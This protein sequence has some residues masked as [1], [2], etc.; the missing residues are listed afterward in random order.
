MFDDDGLGEAPP[1]TPPPPTAS[2][3]PDPRPS[4][5]EPTEPEAPRPSQ[6]SPSLREPFQESDEPQPGP[7]SPAR[8]GSK[9]WHWVRVPDRLDRII[10][11]WLLATAFVLLVF[12]Y[13]RGALT[14]SVDY[15]GVYSFS[16]FFL[17]PSVNYLVP[18]IAAGLTFGNVYAAQ[19]LA[20]F[21]DAFAVTYGCQLFAHEL[22]LRTFDRRRLLVLQVLAATFYLVNPY[23]FS[24]GLVTLAAAVFLSNAAFF[25]VMTQTIRFVRGVLERHPFRRRDALILGVAVGLSAPIALPN[26]VR[27]VA[28]ELAGFVAALLAC[29]VFVRTAEQRSTFWR[30]LRSTLLL[31]LPIAVVFLAYP[32]YSFVTIWLLH[33]G[34]L[35]TI[36]GVNASLVSNTTYNTFANVIRL[37]ARRQFD[38][39]AYST[40][41]ATNPTVFFG[42]YLW[43]VLAVLIPGV[44]V[45][46]RRVVSWRV[47]FAG[48]AALV[49]SIVWSTGTN[50]PFGPVNS[51]ILGPYPLAANIMPNFFLEAEVMTK[52]YPAFIAFSILFLG[53]ALKRRL[54]DPPPDRSTAAVRTRVGEP[55]EP[56]DDGMGAPVVRSSRPPTWLATAAV[57]LATLLVL[58]A[59]YPLYTGEAITFSPKDPISGFWIP[60]P[61]FHARQVLQ[62]G[63]GNALLLPQ[64]STYVLT[65][66][67][68][69]GATLFYSSFN[70]PARVVSPGFYGPYAIYLANIQQEYAQATTP[71]GPASSTT[72][73]AETFT[74]VA[75]VLTQGYPLFSFRA[76]P[77]IN[78]SAFTWL[79][80]SVNVSNPAAMSTY[81]ANQSLWVGL[82]SGG[83]SAASQ[84]GW[85]P[86][87]ATY[88]SVART[89]GGHTFQF[90]VLLGDSASGPGYRT[91]AIN[92]VQFWFRQA[93]STNGVAL[94]GVRVAGVNQSAISPTWVNL[95]HQYSVQYV[96]V[97]NSLVSGQSESSLYV[98]DSIAMLMKS[99]NA[100]LM[101]QAPELQLYSLSI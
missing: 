75:P 40:V 71:I 72:P 62:H 16:G 69:R 45:L 11:S 56:V 3:R 13:T 66:W 17:N 25:V 61:Y 50:A 63:S 60:S 49:V 27:T 38:A 73:I 92:A 43:P 93:G 8:L 86:A 19:Y 10:V 30:S 44:L 51:V 9:V 64:V 1:A 55:D 83:V 79:S 12:A 68:Y 35:T 54:G 21:I 88:Q 57:G 87:G 32:A 29:W 58:T 7:L 82:Q 52:L 100:Q 94:S 67:G 15:V 28:L 41:Y 34:A 23:N 33:P 91:N 42:T 31:A 95:M 20:L 65:D 85:Y 70:Y 78:A 46:F 37:L 81:L 97:D 4:R 59:G 26:L 80:V 39:Y 53:R 14:Y 6:P 96:Y 89:T 36:E 76:T 5:S 48:L 24:W 101:Y 74:P 2:R 84:V 90:V 22:F 18:A 98:N 47:M 99:G 77:A